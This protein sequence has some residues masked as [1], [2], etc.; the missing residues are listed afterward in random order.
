MM[1]NTLSNL[2]RM[3]L[4]LSEMESE[5]QLGDLSEFEKRV[6]LSVAELVS[7]SDSA[8]LGEIAAHPLSKQISR[9]SFFRAL[10]RLESL[11]YI[12]RE[13]GRRGLYNLA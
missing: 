6:L 10:K 1:T 2:A 11:N 4:L 12:Q 7:E 8:A 3:K 13:T 5:L 9:P